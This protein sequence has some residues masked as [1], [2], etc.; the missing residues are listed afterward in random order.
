MLKSNTNTYPI[1]RSNRVLPST[2][3]P[4]GVKGKP[5]WHILICIENSP[6]AAC[7]MPFLLAFNFCAALSASLLS[8]P[9]VLVCLDGGN[10]EMHQV[11]VAIQL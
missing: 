9:T 1:Y 10:G 5:L 11:R 7:F 3:A 4:L 2:H 8:I 6:D